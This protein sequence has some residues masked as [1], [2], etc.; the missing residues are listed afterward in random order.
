M[1]TSI[2]K[3]EIH[4]LIDSSDDETLQSVY[5]LLQESEYTDEF[6]NILN[7]EQAEYYKSKQVITKEAMNNL[8]NEALKK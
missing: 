4:S 3:S 8:I 1:E 5:Q 2:L 7:E 6:K